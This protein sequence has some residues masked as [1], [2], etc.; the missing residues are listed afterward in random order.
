MMNVGKQ[1]AMWMLCVVSMLGVGCDE[2]KKNPVPSE[3]PEVNQPPATDVVPGMTDPVADPGSVPATPNQPENPQPP[4]PAAVVEVKDADPAAI[5]E[6]EKIP[7]GIDVDPR[8][9]K[10][11]GPFKNEDELTFV[12]SELASFGCLLTDEEL[13]G[14]D[15]PQGL[16]DLD[17]LWRLNRNLNI[18]LSNHPTYKYRDTFSLQF[19]LNDL[20]GRIEKVPEYAAARAE[21]ERNELVVQRVLGWFINHMFTIGVTERMAA[22]QN[23]RTICLDPQLRKL[24][25]TLSVES[26]LV[27][28]GLTF[29][30]LPGRAFYFGYDLNGEWA[31][32]AIRDALASQ[33]AL[34]VDLLQDPEKIA[35]QITTGVLV[36]DRLRRLDRV[37][38]TT[39]ADLAMVKAE[40]VGFGCAIDETRLSGCRVPETFA[41]QD[42]LWELLQQFEVMLLNHPVYRDR[43]MVAMERDVSAVLAALGGVADYAARTRTLELQELAVQRIIGWRIDHVVLVGLTKRMAALVH[44]KELCLEE[45]LRQKAAGIPVKRMLVYMSNR[46]VSLG[47]NTYT[48]GYDLSAQEILCQLKT[49]L[50]PEKEEP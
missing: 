35:E 24:A 14:C 10:L 41:D 48:L 19:S 5:A 22:L 13:K 1:F 26:I 49:D 12:R 39:P 31:I 18:M 40:L 38:L 50:C 29:Q 27:S 37:S 45:S 28:P 15:I 2:D 25:R 42:Y 36:E 34:P 44:L 47:D 30:A 46:L 21:V 20:K 6:A 3:Q 16:I 32:R 33:P 43:N 17:Y 4:A 7:T 11:G 9:R 8:I 23:L